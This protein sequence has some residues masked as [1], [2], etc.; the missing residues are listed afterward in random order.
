MLLTAT[1]KIFECTITFVM[2]RYEDIFIF[3]FHIW[4]KRLRGK[5]PGRVQ[6]IIPKVDFYRFFFQFDINCKI[7]RNLIVC[8]DQNL[9]L[10]SYSLK[11]RILFFPLNSFE[12]SFKWVL[13]YILREGNSIQ[14]SIFRVL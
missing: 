11:P 4:R 12:S 14:T 5:I 8:L 10:N 3:S 9:E 13:L 7:L 2:L 1:L 6:S